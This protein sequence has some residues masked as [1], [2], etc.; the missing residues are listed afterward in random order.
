MTYVEKCAAAFQPEWATENVPH[1]VTAARLEQNAKGMD[2]LLD[3]ARMLKERGL[4]FKWFVFG[5]GSYREQ[6]AAYITQHHLQDHLILPGPVPNPYP[7]VKHATLYVQTSRFEGFGNSIAEARM[8]NTPVVTTAYRGWE[9]QMKPGKNGMVAEINA[10]SVADA[11]AHLLLHPEEIE[12]IREYLKTEV[13]GNP[14][15]LEKFNKIVLEE[16]A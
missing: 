8:L 14:E 11:I 15:E 12:T 2:I 6:M 1:L 13:K 5:E 10:E 9:M 4:T 16:G 3:T 7:Y